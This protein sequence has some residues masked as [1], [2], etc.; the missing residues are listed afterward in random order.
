MYAASLEHRGDEMSRRRRITCYISSAIPPLEPP[1]TIDAVTA[2]YYAIVCG[3]L[4]WASAGLSP[5]I[6]RLGAG[7][8][9]GIISALALPV[10]RHA[11]G[12]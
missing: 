12:L 3:C 7:A 5:S 2:T 6:V 4:A 11:T 1:M 8:I 9:V 10:L